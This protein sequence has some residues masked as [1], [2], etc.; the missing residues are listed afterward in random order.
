SVGD[1]QMT[2]ANT[3]NRSSRAGEPLT[4]HAGDSGVDPARERPRG[5]D[6]NGGA[7]RSEQRGGDHRRLGREGRG[8][9]HGR[10][11]EHEGAGEGGARGGHIPYF[12]AAAEDLS[13][14]P[15]YA[16]RA[17]NRHAHKAW[18]AARSSSTSGT[19]SSPYRHVPRMTP[20]PSTRK[21]LRT[22]VSSRP[23]RVW[24]TPNART[25]AAVQSESSG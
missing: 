2:D 6:R 1:L 13:P 4:I 7:R 3:A 10:E 17:G 24:L 22:G 18:A 20:S 16:A 21:Q 15:G 23:S 5:G 14:R 19:S 11:G 25:A 8:G 9:G 12:G